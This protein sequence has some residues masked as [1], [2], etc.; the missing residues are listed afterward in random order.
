[1]FYPLNYRGAD[2]SSI[3]IKGK[4][5]RGAPPI[6]GSPALRQAMPCADLEGS[7]HEAI[8]NVARAIGTARARKSGCA[9]TSIAL[10]ERIGP[11]H[12]ILHDN[13][14]RERVKLRF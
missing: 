3:A 4:D 8:D 2:E 5:T 13:F 7:P 14:F 12:A 11:V 1:M 9:K 10:T 6:Q